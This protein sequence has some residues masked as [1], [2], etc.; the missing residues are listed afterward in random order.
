MLK[1][2]HYSDPINDE[3]HL[4]PTLQEKGYLLA[5]FLLQFFFITE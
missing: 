4:T 5:Q 2:I 3:V 1:C